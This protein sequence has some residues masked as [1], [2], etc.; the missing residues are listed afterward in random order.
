MNEVTNEVTMVN[1]IKNLSDELYATVEKLHETEIALKTA[2][3]DSSDWFMR[4]NEAN[5]ELEILKGAAKLNADLPKMD[6]VNET[7]GR[8]RVL[9]EEQK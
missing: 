4:W 3:N 7:K 6:D 8:I 5:K 1:I 9:E 2:R